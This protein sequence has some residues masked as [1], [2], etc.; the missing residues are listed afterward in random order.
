[1]ATPPGLARGVLGQEVAG[2]RGGGGGGAQAAHRSEGGGGG[3]SMGTDVG[4]VAA[5]GGR[6]GASRPVVAR[7]RAA[8]RA[9]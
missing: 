8:H 4:R 6:A 3:R 9:F 7:R 2:R 1:M 5:G